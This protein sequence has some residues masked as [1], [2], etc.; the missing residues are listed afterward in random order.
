[1]NQFYKN[2]IQQIEPF[3]DRV[4]YFGL[5]EAEV[6]E[7]ELQLDLRFPVYF[8]EFLKTFGVKQ[9]LVFGLITSVTDFA[10][11][12]KYL[13]ETIRRSYVLIGENGGEDFW[14]LNMKNQADTTLYAW[15]HGLDGERVKPVCKFETLLNENIS[16]LSDK[17]IKRE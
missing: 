8:R 17:N 6:L 2:I 1:M 12:T 5:P 9:D 15:Q 14:L 10:E 3:K 11:R 4:F 7:I 13:P 16:Q